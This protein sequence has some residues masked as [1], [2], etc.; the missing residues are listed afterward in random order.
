MAYH[1][2]FTMYITKIKLQFND[3]IPVTLWHNLKEFEI[4]KNRKDSP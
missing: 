1:F 2:I 4:A 3:I